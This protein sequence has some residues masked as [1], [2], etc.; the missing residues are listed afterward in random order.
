MAPCLVF[1]ICSQG[2]AEQAGGGVS[3]SD[4]SGAVVTFDGCNIYSNTAGYDAV[5]PAAQT[6]AFVCPI[7]CPP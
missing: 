2:Q 6:P 5:T 7:P 4:A 3:I 1:M